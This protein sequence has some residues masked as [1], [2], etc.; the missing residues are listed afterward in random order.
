[1]P[2]G[3]WLT[4]FSEVMVV[5]KDGIGRRWTE[6]EVALLT[7]LYPLTPMPEIEAKV[8]K[9]AGQIKNKATNLGLRRDQSIL[10]AT[11]FK[12]GQES[13]NRIEVGERRDDGRN[14]RIKLPCGA[15]VLEHRWVWEQAHGP[16]PDKCVVAARDGN[17][18]NTDLA[19][20][21]LVT[22]DRH[23]RRNQIRKY[24]AELQDVIL[25]QQDLKRAI[26]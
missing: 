4:I 20:L 3:C 5:R 6:Q 14:I 18:R 26:R 2:A 13:Y 7:E 19:N 15:W 17:R 11:R 23:W 10:G 21:M 22:K 8:G 24:P 9:T 16:I 12:P 25:A 1:M